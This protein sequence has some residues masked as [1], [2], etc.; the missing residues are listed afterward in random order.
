[1]VSSNQYVFQLENT[2]AIRLLL[3]LRREENNGKIGINKKILT[4]LIT[5][6]SQSIK[7]RID[8][9]SD[10]GLITVEE[11]KEHPRPHMVYLTPRGREV[12]EKLAEIEEILGE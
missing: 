8:E 3:V 9:L 4:Q 1:M 7:D 11:K 10:I 2:H 6:S 12:A 5:T